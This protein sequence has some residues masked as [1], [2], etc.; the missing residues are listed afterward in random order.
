MI[1]VVYIKQRRIFTQDYWGFGFHQWSRFLKKHIHTTEP[2]QWMRLALSNGPNSYHP[3]PHLMTETN[4][5]PES[6]CS[7]ESGWWTKS[8]NP[9]IPRV[10]DHCQDS[11]Q[12]KHKYINPYWQGMEDIKSHS[13]TG[14]ATILKLKEW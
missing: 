8:K 4:Q 14:L 2:V 11:S 3:F 13:T 10:T 7:S 5:L 12:S 6:L 9:L 1:P